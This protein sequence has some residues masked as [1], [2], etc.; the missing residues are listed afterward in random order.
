MLSRQPPDDLEEE[1]RAQSS[2]KAT[3]L[4][5]PA[6]ASASPTIES[7]VASPRLPTLPTAA[8]RIIELVQRPDV[9]LDELA[10]V[11]S[12]DPALAARFLQR[13]NASF[14]ARA[15]P[16]AR[17]RDALVVLGLRAVKPLALGFSLVAH[18]RSLDGSA[19]D[20]AAFWTRSLFAASIARAIA[21]A[22]NTAEPDDAF[23]GG[24]LH[25]LGSVAMAR[26]IGTG[27]DTLACGAAGDPRL[28]SELERESFGF[29]HAE[30]GGAL[31]EQWNLPRPITAAMRH[32]LAPDEAPARF[33]AFVRCVA[34]GAAGSR[35]FVGSE[36]GAAL[37]EFHDGCERWFGMTRMQSEALL[38]PAHEEA[39]AMRVL[40]DLPAIDGESA[41][42]ILSRANEALQSLSLAAVQEA[43]NL[44]RENTDLSA[45][46][47]TDA[48]TG[49][50]TRGRLDA[51]M[52]EQF[53]LARGTGQSLSVIF[54]DLDHFKQV[55]DSLGHQAGDRALQMVG[56]VLSQEL[57]RTDFVGRY[58]GEEFL[59]V[60]PGSQLHGAAVLAQRL[61]QA[62]SAARTN[63]ADGDE[64]GV[65]ASF[66]VA[67]YVPGAH[68]TAADLVGAA[69]R[70]LYAAKAA[71]RNAVRIGETPLHPGQAVA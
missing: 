12:T 13:A 60:C 2:R 14:Y 25:S 4:D 20:Y 44:E 41:S 38:E 17:V 32:Y 62:I 31:A 52:A 16:A 21:T 70:G 37:G 8:L 59:V 68:R 43:A 33:Q 5:N 40:L 65:T 9:G 57:R 22:T 1:G 29:D 67:A 47:A 24:L 30:A 49:V 28:L 56:S 55:N 34:A 51:I 23:L 7:I 50:A 64:F 3:P 66:G 61:R 18:M 27:Y 19:F 42:D 54:L 36:P 63:G 35:V 39:A 69:D 53:E 10:E 45:Q 71:G 26:A 15:H 6:S 58:G 48:L 46:A 11:I